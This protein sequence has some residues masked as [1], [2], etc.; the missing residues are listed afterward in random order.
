[1]K[2]I[3]ISSITVIA[4]CAALLAYARENSQHPKFSDPLG[5]E[6]SALYPLNMGRIDLG[7][8]LTFRV[9]TGSAISMITSEDIELLKK[10]GIPVD[11]G[12]WPSINR[13]YS[14]DIYWATKRYIVSLPV[15][16]PEFMADSLGNGGVYKV[17]GELINRIENVTFIPANEGFESTIGADILELFTMEFQYGRNAVVM[18]QNTPEGFQMLECLETTPEISDFFGCGSR[19]YLPMTVDGNPNR[20]MVDTSFRRAAVKFPSEDTVHVHDTLM[21]TLIYSSRGTFR[22]KYLPNAWVRIGNRAG[23]H[24]I[25]FGDDGEEPYAFN[26]F[27]YFGQDVLIDFPNRRICLRPTA[28]LRN[29]PGLL[30][31]L[32][33]SILSL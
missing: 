26:P 6:A 24:A 12:W 7:D 22:A 23:S 30:G 9:D 33:D 14:N 13:S 25:F 15:Y 16:R 27:N 21:P 11:S 19:Y 31:N 32:S 17:P 4:I 28:N 3:L 5:G 29:N 20:F 8:G 2:K 10:R 1:M 18:R